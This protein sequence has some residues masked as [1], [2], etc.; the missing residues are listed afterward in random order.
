MSDTNSALTMTRYGHSEMK[1]NV[2]AEPE[3]LRWLHVRYSKGTSIE[4]MQQELRN[5]GRNEFEIDLILNYIRDYVRN[6]MGI[7]PDNSRSASE[8][9]LGI[10]CEKLATYLRI[11]IVNCG[12]NLARIQ[13]PSAAVP[14]ASYRISDE[15]LVQWKAYYDTAETI[16][17]V[18]ELQGKD[19]EVNRDSLGLLIA[20]LSRRL[21]EYKAREKQVLD[22]VQR[23]VDERNITE[24]SRFTAAPAIAANIGWL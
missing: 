14:G 11:D 18:P 2:P 15:L 7:D 13:T 10:R 3:Y 6:E 21:L 1:P 20:E 22:T 24:L 4:T 5:L 9:A 17:T 23:L 19:L 16:A 8:E 12:I